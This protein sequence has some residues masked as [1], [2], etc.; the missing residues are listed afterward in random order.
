VKVLLDEN[1][2]LG[3]LRRLHADGLAAEHVI[4]I[5]SRGLAINGIL[6]ILMRFEFDP[7]KSAANKA[8]HGIDFVEGQTIWNDPDRLEIPARSLDE[9]R[10]QVLGRVGE[11][12]WSAFVTYRNE[13]IRIISI[14][15]ARPDEAAR[16][17]AD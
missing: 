10:F 7:A 1:F 4:T 8:K 17:L 16:Y 2:P 14:R 12:T 15:H 13:T 11:R 6:S 3:L 9:P 5:G